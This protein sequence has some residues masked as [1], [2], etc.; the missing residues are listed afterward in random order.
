MFSGMFGALETMR[1][2]VSAERTVYRYPLQ[3]KSVR[4][5]YILDVLY[6]YHKFF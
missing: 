1:T 6:L 2:G 5:W 3:R 4:I